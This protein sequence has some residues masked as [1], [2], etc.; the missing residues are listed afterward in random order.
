VRSRRAIILRREGDLDAL[1]RHLLLELKNC[2]REVLNDVDFLKKCLIETAESIGATVVNS[3]FHQ[4]SPYG[5]SGVVVVA[6]SHLCIHTW[7]EYG[8]AAVDVFTCG[9]TIEPSDA[10]DILVNKLESEEPSF[11][12]LKRGLIEIETGSCGITS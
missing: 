9:S 2:N 8:Y 3:A 12:E 5:I 6:E 1:G 11:M 10:V 7:P 4:F